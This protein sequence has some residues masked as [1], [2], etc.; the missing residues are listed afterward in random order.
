MKPATA[1]RVTLADLARCGVGHTVVTMLI[2]PEGFSTYDRRES[3][4]H[5]AGPGAC[6]GVEGGPDEEE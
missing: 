5:A 1:G 6:T 2:D 3:L 4:L